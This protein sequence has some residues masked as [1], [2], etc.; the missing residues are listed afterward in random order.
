MSPGSWRFSVALAGVRSAARGLQTRAAVQTRGRVQ[1][2][3]Q[4]GQPDVVQWASVAI[5]GGG[6]TPVSRSFVC[7][8]PPRVRHTGRSMAAARAPGVQGGSRAPGGAPGTQSERT[9][10]LGVPPGD[11]PQVR[12]LGMRPWELVRSA[13]RPCI[14]GVGSASTA[15]HA[16]TFG[17]RRTI[18]RTKACRKRRSGYT[19]GRPRPRVGGAGLG[20]ASTSLTLVTSKDACC[21]IGHLRTRWFGEPLCYG[22]SRAR[23][24]SGAA[25]E[26]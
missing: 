22:D 3:T 14:S 18:M 19:A 13:R 20:I 5:E 12:R 10:W 17:Q 2:Y 9:R 11:V 23:E 26:L 15:K 8:P 6:T 7:Q 1:P 16:C 21:N 25:Q 4:P 24:S